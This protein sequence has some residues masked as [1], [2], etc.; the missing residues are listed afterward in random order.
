[1]RA[2]N[3]L[4]SGTPSQVTNLGTFVIWG[5]L[6]CTLVLAPV[7]LILIIWKYLEVK[8]QVYELTNQRLKMHSGVLSKKIEELEL[9]RV[10]DTQFEQPFFLRLFGLG[11]VILF[12]TDSTSPEIILPAIPNAQGVREQIRNAVEETRD[13]KRVRVSELD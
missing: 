4:W 13:S 12:T 2:E 5:I 1:M 8:N 7:S 11:N 10:R 9:Y 6:A 3:I